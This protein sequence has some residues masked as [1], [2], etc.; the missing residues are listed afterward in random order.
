MKKIE[1]MAIED[2]KRMALAEMFY[3]EGAGT[4]RKLLNAEIDSKLVE[5]ADTDYGQQFVWAYQDLD[6]NKIAQAAIK[7][8]KALDRSAKI[9]QNTRAFKSGNYGNLTNDIAVAVGVYIVLNKTGYDKK[10]EAEAKKAW[11]RIKTEYKARNL[12]VVL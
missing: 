1:K 12:K 3:G 5:H 4:R 8:R 2:A 10:I 7:Q 6:M 11:L 9:A